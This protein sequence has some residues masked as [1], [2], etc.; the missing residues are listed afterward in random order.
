MT[1]Q[2]LLDLG[3][4]RV[5][6]NRLV[7]F[8][9]DPFGARWVSQEGSKRSGLRGKSLGTICLRHAAGYEVLLLLDNGRIES[10]APDSLY[11]E[12]QDAGAAT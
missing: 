8:N 9:P 4:M 12:R 1:E 6:L 5:D 11:P 10:F 2:Q 3:A 7:V